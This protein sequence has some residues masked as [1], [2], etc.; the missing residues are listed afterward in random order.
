MI[1]NQMA[2]IARRAFA[3][4]FRPKIHST[5]QD[6]ENCFFNGRSGLTLCTR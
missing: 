3:D 6:R 2:R 1:A 5:Q 4:T